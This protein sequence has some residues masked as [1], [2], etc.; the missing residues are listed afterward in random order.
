MSPHFVIRAAQP[1]DAAAITGLYN[2][3]VE[4]TTATFQHE[5]LGEADFREQIAA[6]DDR[7]PFLVGL[8]DDQLIGYCYADVFKSRCG[9][10][11][12]YESSIYVAPAAAGQGAGKAL[13]RALIAALQAT[14]AYRLVAI[15]SLPNPASVAL[16][17]HLG[18][19]HAGT[20]PAVGWK[21]GKWIDSG[22]WVLRLK[23][24]DPAE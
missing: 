21:F 9:Y 12:T 3:Y 23:D 24:S 18:F 10:R 19:V 14:P 6:A 1:D 16:H 5:P 11:Y 8:A 7:R 15:I 17:E 4:N 13:M 22:Y 20:L 2:Y